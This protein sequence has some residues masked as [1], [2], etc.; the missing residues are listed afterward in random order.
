MHS[1]ALI[2]YWYA[3]AALYKP[4]LTLCIPASVGLIIKVSCLSGED[5]TKQKPRKQHHSY[6]EFQIIA[7]RF[8]M[9][10]EQMNTV[11]DS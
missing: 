2:F 6:K 10:G 3:E 4:A 9:H 1:H 11:F 7:L 5:T 8:K